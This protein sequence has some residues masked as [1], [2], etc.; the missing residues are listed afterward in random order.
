MSENAPEKETEKTDP[1]PEPE[2]TAEE[3]PAPPH[4]PAPVEKDSDLHH[5]VAGLQESVDSL[6][7][8]VAALTETVANAAKATAHHANDEQPVKQPWTHRGSK[9]RPVEHEGGES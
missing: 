9:P 2:K 7:G 4:E 6:I 1:A 3:H 5:T 8:T